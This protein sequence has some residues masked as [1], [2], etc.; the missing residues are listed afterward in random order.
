MACIAPDKRGIK[1][2]NFP[3]KHILRVFIRSASVRRMNT[4][5][6]FSGEMRENVIDL[7]SLGAHVHFHSLRFRCFRTLVH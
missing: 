7:S 3:Q 4:Y 1:I 2:I 6:I 5:N